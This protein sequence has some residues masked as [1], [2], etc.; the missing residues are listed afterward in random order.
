M[1]IEFPSEVLLQ[2]FSHLA[3]S[4]WKSIRR[5]SKE[6]SVTAAKHVFDE[7]R[8]APA[9]RAIAS[10]KALSSHEHLRLIP[11]RLRVEAKL[12]DPNL[13]VHQFLQHLV[14]QIRLCSQCWGWPPSS[15]ALLLGSDAI[16]LHASRPL[17]FSS[18]ESVWREGELCVDSAVRSRYAAYLDC[19]NQQQRWTASRQR[20]ILR[21]ALPKLPNI[22]HVIFSAT[23]LT[24]ETFEAWSTGKGGLLLGLDPVQQAPID[25]HLSELVHVLESPFHTIK[26]LTL[27]VNGRVSIMKG[28]S[29]FLQHIEHFTVRLGPCFCDEDTSPL[30]DLIRSMIRLQTLDVQF[31]SC[32]GT[33]DTSFWALR[34]ILQMP[35][36]TSTSFK[37]LCLVNAVTQVDD[38]VAFARRQPLVREIVLVDS[39]M[40][41]HNGKNTLAMESTQSL[42]PCDAKSLETARS[43]HQG[44]HRL[45][46]VSPHCM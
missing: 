22:H 23:S 26:S 28:G 45:S 44:V 10:L 41:Q 2:I 1:M 3:K 25:D 12:V 34:P 35:P 5:L 9:D 31:S 32:S 29:Y 7:I 38:L 8:L 11:S 37:R 19:V 20:D 21:R 15:E 24:A 6:W 16:M 36:C 27:E 17:P 33:S 30:V 46:V 39:H 43:R 40:V 18:V 14:R 4:D 13:S 42:W